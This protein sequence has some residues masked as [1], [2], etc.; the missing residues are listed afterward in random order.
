[1][2]T[3][4]LGL[5]WRELVQGGSVLSH[6]QPREKEGTKRITLEWLASK[7][8]S[9]D[10]RASFIGLLA[11]QLHRTG[12][13]QGPTFGLMLCY[14]KGVQRALSVRKKN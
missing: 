1:M 12:T 10:F 11:V 13:L 7:E 9:Q 8:G 2:V 14:C 3:R 6:L 4:D 5:V